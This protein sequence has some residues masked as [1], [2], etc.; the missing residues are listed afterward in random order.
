MTVFL[1]G[2]PLIVALVLIA[3]PSAQVGP[4]DP[5][6][7]RRMIAASHLGGKYDQTVD[8]ESAYEMLQKRVA[9]TA[10]PADGDAGA[11]RQATRSEDRVECG[12]F[13]IEYA[14]RAGDRSR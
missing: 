7:R 13:G 6:E 1:I 9:G 14:R 8:R 5:S 11:P 3:P 10:T 12:L 4:L 2:W